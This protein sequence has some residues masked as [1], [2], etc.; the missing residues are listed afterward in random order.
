MQEYKYIYCVSVE[1]YRHSINIFLFLH[2][3]PLES[4]RIQIYLL[5]VC[6]MIPT[7]YNYIINIFLFLHFPSLECARIQI[8]LLCVSGVIPTHY[9]YIINIFLFLHFPPLESARIQI[10]LLCVSG[11]I[12]TNYKHVCILAISTLKIATRAVEACRWSLHSRI[13]AT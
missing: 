13:T 12:P 1:W 4:A 5:C 8:Y 3:P 10:Y 11:V 7:H 9:K 6:G 2:F